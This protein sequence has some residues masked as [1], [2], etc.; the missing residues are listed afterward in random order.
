MTMTWMGMLANSYGFD[1]HGDPVSRRRL[2]IYFHGVNGT[3][4]ADYGMFNVV[5]EGDR[6]EGKEPPEPSIPSSPGHEREWLDSIKSRQQP[7]A[8]VFYHTKVDVPLVLA[9]FSLKL[10]RSISFDPATRKIVGDDEAARLSVPEYRDPWKFPKEYL[11][12]GA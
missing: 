8:S 1:L 7:S 9:N 4:F 10:G 12:Q 5:P 6:M 11:E 3:M 2:G